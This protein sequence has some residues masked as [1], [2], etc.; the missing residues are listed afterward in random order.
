MS[1]GAGQRIQELFS[2]AFVERT[3]NIML[4]GPSGV[5]KIHLAIALGMLRRKRG[6]SPFCQC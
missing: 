1:V 4:L 6:S 2:L 3:E 5:G